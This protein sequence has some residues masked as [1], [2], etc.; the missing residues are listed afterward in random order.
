MEQQSL[1]I[2]AMTTRILQASTFNN[3]ECTVQ[4]TRSQQALAMAIRSSTQITS[5]IPIESGR[6]T[7]A[8]GKGK[9]MSFIRSTSRHVETRFRPEESPSRPE[10]HHLHECFNHPRQQTANIA[11]SVKVFSKMVERPEVCDFAMHGV[12][13]TG[14]LTTFDLLATQ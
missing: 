5:I 8:R 10:S 1:G 2:P 3:V 13:K 14:F 12:S 6:Q 4:L 9:V 11:G 7:A